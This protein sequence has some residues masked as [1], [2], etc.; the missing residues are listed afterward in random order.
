MSVHE[1][2]RAL[3]PDVQSPTSPGQVAGLAERL[4]TLWRE[5]LGIPDAGM[6]ENFFDAGGSSLLAVRLAGRMTAQ[7]GCMVTAADIL[8][9]PTIRQL[10]RKVGGDEPGLDR[11]AGDSRAAM[12]RKAFTL[13][14]PVR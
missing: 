10:A 7:L 6:D 12:Q 13:R 2:K 14:R 9:Y 4:L 8:A 3:E 11:A 5:S 1:Q